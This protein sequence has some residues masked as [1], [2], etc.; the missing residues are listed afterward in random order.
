MQHVR[1]QQT[2]IPT[3]SSTF[4]SVPGPP[5]ALTFLIPLNLYIDSPLSFLFLSPHSFCSLLPPPCSC[6]SFF[7]FSFSSSLCHSCLLDFF[8][9]LILFVS[10]FDILLFLF[11]LLIFF[12]QVL[13]FKL[14]PFLFIVSLLLLLTFFSFDIPLL[15]F[16]NTA[17]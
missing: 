12:Y 9:Y 15:P 16:V 4:A 11:V 13:F 7:P 3:S 17:I 8:L 10:E 1:T 2:G 5:P 6:C 14:F